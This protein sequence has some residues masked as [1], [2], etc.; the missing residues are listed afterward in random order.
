MSKPPKPSS[1]TD[2]KVRVRQRYRKWVDTAVCLPLLGV[3]LLASP[4]VDI[5]A[6]PVSDP[7]ILFGLWAAL[8]GACWLHG[9]A[10]PTKQEGEG[11]G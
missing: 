11:D 3:L 10:H 4:L 1:T 7:L 5:L 9:R 6:Q 2:S 8:I